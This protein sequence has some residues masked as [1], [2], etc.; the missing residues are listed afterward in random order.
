MV[1]DE[2]DVGGV[3]DE[4]VDEIHEEIG[5][6]VIQYETLQRRVGGVE[7]RG[8]VGENSAGGEEYCGGA[9]S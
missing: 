3:E 4:I 1:A 2:E 5:N 7:I 9:V 6:A 8:R